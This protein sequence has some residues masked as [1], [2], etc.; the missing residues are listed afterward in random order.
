[1]TRL[2]GRLDRLARRVGCGPTLLVVIAHLGLDSAIELREP[3]GPLR[4][5][6]LPSETNDEFRRRFFDLRLLEP[7]PVGAV[8]VAV[9]VYGGEQIRG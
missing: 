1:M 6:R 4:V 8:S 5:V 9:A 7:R 3:E 2:K